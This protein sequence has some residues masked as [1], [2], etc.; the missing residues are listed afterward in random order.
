MDLSRLASQHLNVKI[1]LTNPHGSSW[2]IG[3]LEDTIYSDNPQE[4][5]EWG[6]FYL[7]EYV[8]MEVLGTVEDMPCQGTQLVIVVGE[9]GH[10]YG[11]DDQTLH[12]VASSITELC[13]SGIQYPGIKTFYR[14]EC[15]KNMV[16]ESTAMKHLTFE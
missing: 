16:S 7:P 14:G 6:K 12:L 3:G 13:T 10:I 11:H 15:F 2:R 1:P 9:D 8:K 4:V 5:E